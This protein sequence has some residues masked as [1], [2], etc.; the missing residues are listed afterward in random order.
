MPKTFS[1][2]R[3]LT[4]TS[5]ESLA[6]YFSATGIET[7]IDFTELDEADVKPIMNFIEGL[8]RET[9]AVVESNFKE[10]HALS[11]KGGIK[12]LLQEAR[13]DF[14]E[15]SGELAIIDGHEDKVMW[16]FLNRTK[17]FASASTW[18]RIDAMARWRHRRNL[19]S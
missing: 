6:N 14:D 18:R 13:D 16:V 3:F 12:I 4:V 19:P 8:P 15:I 11:N 9:L 2:K 10:I 17:V 5:N 1:M 7:G